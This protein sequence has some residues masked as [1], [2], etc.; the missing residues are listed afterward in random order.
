MPARFA[1]HGDDDE[2][3]DEEEEN[4]EEQKKRANFNR[5]FLKQ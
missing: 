3:D 2:D 5:Y 1:S 4:E